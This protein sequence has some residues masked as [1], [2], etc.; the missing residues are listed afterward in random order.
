M[1]S[2]VGAL[3]FAQALIDRT[4]LANNEYWALAPAGTGGVESGFTDL[5]QSVLL[6]KLLGDIFERIGCIV[7]ADFHAAGQCL[8]N[9][10]EL[11]LQL[12]VGFLEFL[13]VEALA[14]A[15]L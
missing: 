9:Q 8:G 12:A 3:D 10:I 7:G 4:V 6:D 2:G 11:L 13:L 14:L 1:R 15:C 5:L